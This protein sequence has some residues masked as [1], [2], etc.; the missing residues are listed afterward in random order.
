MRTYT[1]ES[2][3]AWSI[4]SGS[5][6]LSAAG[7]QFRNRMYVDISALTN[8]EKTVPRCLGLLLV[9]LRYHFGKYT[10]SLIGCILRTANARRKPSADSMFI[11][12]ET[13]MSANEPILIALMGFYARRRIT[14]VSSCWR[15]SDKNETSGQGKFSVRV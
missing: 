10:L 13:P 14:V 7:I 2:S 6:I 11:P 4:N 1:A 5:G 8:L 3:P 15:K 9:P 12:A